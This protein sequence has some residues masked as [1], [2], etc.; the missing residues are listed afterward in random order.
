VASLGL[1]I[2]IGKEGQKRINIAMAF[3]GKEV[4]RSTNRQVINNNCA[5]ALVFM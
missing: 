1:K 5:I 3:V 4:N 2:E